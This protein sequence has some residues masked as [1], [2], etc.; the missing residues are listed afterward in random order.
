MGSTGYRVAALTRYQTITVG[1]Y[2]LQVGNIIATEATNYKVGDV[3]L[4][5]MNLSADS[6]LIKSHIY[7]IDNVYYYVVPE[8]GSD[9][10]SYYKIRLTEAGNSLEDDGIPTYEKAEM[11]KES[12]TTKVD[13]RNENLSVDISDETGKVLMIKL[14]NEDFYATDS[15]YDEE[16]KTYTVQTTEGTTFYVKVLEDGKVEISQ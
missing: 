13:A 8:K 3:Y 16:T 10:V 12:A 6:S 5:D 1:H 14:L 2:S 7:M 9:K 11:E 15:T 4:T